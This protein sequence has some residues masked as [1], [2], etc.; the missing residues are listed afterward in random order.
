MRLRLVHV[1]DTR[2]SEPAY[3]VIPFRDVVAVGVG[4][5][6]RLYALGKKQL[7]RTVEYRAADRNRIC[8][9]S[10][11]GGDRLFV[12]D[13]QESVTLFK[14]VSRMGISA[15]NGGAPSGN[16]VGDGMGMNGYGGGQRVVELNHGGRLVAIASKELSRWVTY[17]HTL[18]YSTVRQ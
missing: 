17:L 10:S 5:A 1:N 6:I 8:A 14:Y 18:D 7:L 15:A 12:A 3:V 11:A 13:K 4:K 9:M 2:I 16:A